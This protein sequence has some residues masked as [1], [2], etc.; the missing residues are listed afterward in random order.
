[1]N[2]NVP[3]ESGASMIDRFFNMMMD[4]PSQVYYALTAGSIIA[5]AMLYLSGKRHLALFV[6]EWAP[7]LLVSALFYKLLRPSNE[8]VAENL[9]QATNQFTR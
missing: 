8:N 4:V 5:S 3:S 7:T 2:V 6:G 9:R 1:V